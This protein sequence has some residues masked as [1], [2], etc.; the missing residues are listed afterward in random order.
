M[1]V[2]SL[3]T[4][5]YFPKEIPVWQLWIYFSDHVGFVAVNLQILFGALY[6]F[7]QLRR[8]M[9]LSLQQVEDLFNQHIPIHTQSMLSKP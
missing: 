3:R 7:A 1:E 5:V 6:C 9:A 4:S 2:V 8:V